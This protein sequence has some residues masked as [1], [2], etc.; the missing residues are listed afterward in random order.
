MPPRKAPT[1][2]QRRLGAELRKMREHA[3]LSPNESA[4][5]LGSD[6]TNISNIEAGRFGVSA[7][8]VHALA[9][10]YECPDPAYVE[11]LAAMAEERDKGWW[12]EYRG[13]LPADLLDLAETEAHAAGIRAVQVTHVPGLLQTEE[14]AK[15]VFEE[16]VPPQSPAQLRRTLSFRMKRRDVLDRDVPLD[17]IFIIHESA[18]RMEFGGPRL[19]EGS[20]NTC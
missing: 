7:D 10:N 11:A 15:A 14:Y 6:R 20:S 9:A 3:G 2:R 1:A 4:A 18:L 13:Q 8:R 19:Q 16:G 17:C 5:L 12:E